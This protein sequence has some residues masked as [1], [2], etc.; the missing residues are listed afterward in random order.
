[1]K[2]TKRNARVF[3]I[4]CSI[5]MMAAVKG[6]EQSH[7]FEYSVREEMKATKKREEEKGTEEKIA[8]G[9]IARCR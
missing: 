1:M 6:G 5:A 4:S 9:T 7:W 2:S 8:L 3:R